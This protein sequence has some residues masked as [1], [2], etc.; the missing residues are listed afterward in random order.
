MQ[1]YLTIL[2]KWIFQ[3]VLDDP[4]SEFIIKEDKSQNKENIANDFSDKY[5]TEKWSFNNPMMPIF[6]ERYKQKILH[7]GK[8][9]ACIRE[10]GKEVRYPYEE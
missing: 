9:L 2:K 8:Y 3:G 6:L 10:C 1:P 7:A 4:F 5:W